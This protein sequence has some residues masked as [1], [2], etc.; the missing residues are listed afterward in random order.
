[1]IGY[2]KDTVDLNTFGELLEQNIVWQKT[3]IFVNMILSLIIIHW[4]ADEMVFRSPLHRFVCHAIQTNF[5]AHPDTF[6]VG[7]GD[8]VVGAQRWLF[9]YAQGQEYMQPGPSLEG[10]ES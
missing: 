2:L 5:G 8:E 10:C 3:F 1:M 7:N 9:I 4:V 6:S